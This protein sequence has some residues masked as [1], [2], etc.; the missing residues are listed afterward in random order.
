LSNREAGMP[1]NVKGPPPGVGAAPEYCHATQPD[2]PQIAPSATPPQAE[3][4]RLVRPLRP[5][6]I[7]VRITAADG[8]SAI[9]R[10][11]HFRLSD[12][13]L[14]RLIAVAMRVEARR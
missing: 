7:D 1:P 10:S 2:D 14:E 5:R 4:F 8:R 9:G 6:R 13:D 11:R 12:F 3:I